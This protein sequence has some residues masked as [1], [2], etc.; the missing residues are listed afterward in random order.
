MIG[1]SRTLV[2]VGSS[3]HGWIPDRSNCQSPPSAF[4]LPAKEQS[5]QGFLL[6]VL[7]TQSWVPKSRCRSPVMNQSEV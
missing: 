6:L 1:F 7:V 5:L 3:A 2:Q 4:V